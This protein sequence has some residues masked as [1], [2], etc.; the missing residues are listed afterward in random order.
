M[1]GSEL[2]HELRPQWTQ[3]AFAWRPPPLDR[4]I[5]AQH[6]GF[7]F[8]GVPDVDVHWA[9]SSESKGPE[10]DDR[11][12]AELRNYT[13]LALRVHKPFTHKGRAPSQPFYTARIKASAKAALRRHLEEFYGCSRMAMYPDYEGFS[14]FTRQRAL[15]EE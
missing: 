6:G 14:E 10:I 15:P 7:L 5:T 4:R 2:S 1:D 13:S 8:G 3:A 9:R 12:V 11:P